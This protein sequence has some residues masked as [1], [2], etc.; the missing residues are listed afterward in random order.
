MSFQPNDVV[1]LVEDHLSMKGGVKKI[2]A[3]GSLGRVCRVTSSGTGWV[4]FG[5]GCQRLNEKFLEHANG[6]AP[7][8]TQPCRKGTP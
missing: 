8:C 6:S 7:N 3:E 1:R 2:L 4:Q 5:S